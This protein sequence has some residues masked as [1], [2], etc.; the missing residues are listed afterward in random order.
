M[1]YLK[2]EANTQA[3]LANIIEDGKVVTMF[4][5][6][7]FMN[8]FDLHRAEANDQQYLHLLMVDPGSA[9]VK[10]KFTGQDMPVLTMP[11][12]R[13]R[14]GRF[15][16]HFQRTLN[17]Q[18]DFSPASLQALETLLRMYMPP[19]KMKQV[20]T[21]DLIPQIKELDGIVL[22]GSLYLGEVAIRNI[23]GKWDIFDEMKEGLTQKVW[24]GHFYL[25]PVVIFPNGENVPPLNALTNVLSEPSKTIPMYYQ[26]FRERAGL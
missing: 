14:L 11:V 10:R 5:L 16:E 12:L 15:V 6:E 3:G 24:E 17:V 9:M 21:L 1:G 13:E 18:V 4:D 19:A 23:G 7:Q 8:N 22:D 20:L 2:F 25:G 26:K